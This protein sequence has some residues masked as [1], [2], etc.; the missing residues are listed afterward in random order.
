MKMNQSL[1]MELDLRQVIKECLMNQGK[2][3]GIIVDGQRI[4]IG[5][6]KAY[7]EGLFRLHRNEFRVGPIFP[8][9]T[10]NHDAQKFLNFLKRLQSVPNEN[11]KFLN[12]VL[13]NESDIHYASSPGRVDVLGG[14]ADLSGSFALQYPTAKRVFCFVQFESGKIGKGEINLMTVSVPS[15]SALERDEIIKYVSTKFTS[16]NISKIYSSTIIQAKQ[17]GEILKSECLLKGSNDQWSF[18]LIGILRSMLEIKLKLESSFDRILMSTTINIVCISDIPWN[19]GLASSAAVQTAASIAI[20]NALKIPTF[21]LDSPSLVELCRRNE[22]EVVGSKCGVMDFLAVSQKFHGHNSDSKIIGITCKLPL[23]T[24]PYLVPLPSDLSV[25]AIDSG[26][27]RSTN[28]RPY[29]NVRISAAI[30]K[31]V[32]MNKLGEE[33]EYLCD[34]M[35][36]QLSYIH[37]NLRDDMSGQSILSE[38]EHL[39]PEDVCKDIELHN[40]YNVFSATMHPVEENFRANILESILRNLHNNQSLNENS[41][42]SHNQI[43]E[44]LKQSHLSYSK[45]KLGSHQTDTLV[46]LLLNLPHVIGARISGGGGGGSVA[47]L[48]RNSVTTN[49]FESIQEAYYRKTGLNFIVHK[50]SS[51]AAQYHGLLLGKYR[52][53]FSTIVI[54]NLPRL[55]FVN[56]GFPP[57]FNGGSEVYAQTLAIKMLHS[58]MFSSVHVFTREHDP[59]MPDFKVR[60]TSDILEREL[61]IFLMNYPR[62]AAYYRFIVEPADKA[63]QAILA[64][65]RPD[66]V[67]F[68]HLNH[69]SLNFPVIAKSSGATVVYTL[70]DFWFMCPRGQFLVTGVTDANGEPWKQCESQQDAKCARQCYVGRYG[71]RI[72][73]YEISYWTK[74]IEYRMAAVKI[75]CK[76]I[77][78]FVAPSK[79]LMHRFVEEFKLPSEKVIFE[80]YGFDRNRLKARCRSP[81]NGQFVFAYIGRHQPAKGVNLLVD[82]AL[83][84]LKTDNHTFKVKIFGRLEENST[85]ALKKRISESFPHVSASPFVWDTEYNNVDIVKTVFNEIDCLVVPS[86]WEENAPL[87]IH[88]AFQCKIPVITSDCGGMGELVKDC[89]NGLTFTHRDVDSLAVAMQKALKNP[90]HLKILANRGYLGSYDGQ[91][92]CIHTHVKN[93]VKLY[94]QTGNTSTPVVSTSTKGIAPIESPWRVTFDTNPDDCNF[95][96][97]MCEQHSEFSPHQSNR[98]ARGIRRRRMDINLV[99]SVVAELAPRGLKEIIPTTMG[100]PLQ[101]KEFPEFIQI[102]KEY[103]VKMNLTTNGS[104]FGRGVNEWAAVIIP[105]TSD[106][107]ISWNGITTKTQQSIMKGSTLQNQISNLKS[108]IKIRDE[109]ATAGGNYCSITLQ[110]TFMQKNLLEIPEILKFAMECG[111][112][113]VKGHHLWAHFEEIKDEN[114]RRNSASIQNWNEIASQCR[115]IVANNPRKDGKPF[116]LENFESL[117]EQLGVAEA[118]ANTVCPFLGKEAWVNHEGRFDPCC[119]PDEERK[120]LGSF[121]TVNRS[122]LA[123]WN[124]PEYKDLAK[125]YKEFSLCRGCTMRKAP[126]P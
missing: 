54:K 86:I 66:V 46:N 19:A 37:Q 48:V 120:S 102:C 16:T 87:V 106:I 101:Y 26:V 55:L 83:Q 97:T 2:L 34:L 85:I 50:G 29:G 81:C 17:L 9:T 52:R 11:A 56:H 32:V 36:S 77:D 39:L 95:S 88:E 69:L 8:S 67:H 70:H 63:F 71:S 125:N 65:V 84:L 41:S 123:I 10:N 61:P 91:I 15:L 107:K 122:L 112:D 82:A 64:K 89:V 23:E 20:A 53:L 6:P 114:L 60:M 109:V 79:Y 33:I 1:E 119:A 30:G 99:R 24:P 74:W 93:L 62:E 44:L 12:Y 104:F 14:F 90:S 22:N 98:K 96:C 110:L 28:S 80:P 13:N 117:S 94:S 21:Y 51:G 116:R 3:Y 126:S 18:Y 27:P 45:C 78:W 111:C 40:N 58:N 7:I 75:A 72:D 31:H 115:D 108:L 5:N 57:D 43:G 92:P 59:Y 118:G 76:S 105:C 35:P 113:R 47:V 42:R 25:I 68:H 121:G 73:D 49:M 103:N 4:D 38:Y 100:E 124:S